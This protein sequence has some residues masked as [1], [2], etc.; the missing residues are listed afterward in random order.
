MVTMVS[1]TPSCAW[2]CCS[3]LGC[4][5]F[6]V[7]DIGAV[8]QPEIDEEDRRIGRREEALAH[9]A[10]ADRRDDHQRSQH[11]QRNGA[12]AQQFAQ[13]IAIDAE[14]PTIIR[15]F[16]RLIGFWLGHFLFFKRPF[17]EYRRQGQGGEPA[18]HQGNQQYLEQ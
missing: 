17:G 14:Q 11:P 10:K 3:N 1:L 15:G 18:Q 7:G 4:N 16:D 13:Q 2:I 5:L 9:V 6:G 8:G 12:L